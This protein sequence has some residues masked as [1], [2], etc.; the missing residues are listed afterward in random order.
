MLFFDD[1]ALT[2]ATDCIRR[3]PDKRSAIR[4]HSLPHI[5]NRTLFTHSDQF[6][7]TLTYALRNLT[8]A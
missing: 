6:C 7:F 5:N 1:A 8:Y 2:G 4:H 3:R